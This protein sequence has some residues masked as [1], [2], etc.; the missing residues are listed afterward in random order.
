MKR[1]RVAIVLGMALSLMVG[2]CAAAQENDKT[3]DIY[4]LD[5]AGVHRPLS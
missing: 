2:V 4:F 5:M 1:I 3:L